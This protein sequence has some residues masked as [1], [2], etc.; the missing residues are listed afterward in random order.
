VITLAPDA[1]AF[2]DAIGDALASRSPEDAGR[3]IEVAR[4]NAWAPR[5]DRM[6]ALV[7]EALA[8]R[9]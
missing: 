9:A 1:R 7:E 6:V 2:V 5:I 4:G 3:R 8:A